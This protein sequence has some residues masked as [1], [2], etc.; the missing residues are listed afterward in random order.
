MT[1]LAAQLVVLG[2]GIEQQRTG[3][4]GQWRQRQQVV[5]LEIGDE[6]P[7]ARR[8]RRLE[9]RTD[10]A[11]RRHD[12]LDQ[13]VRMAQ[14]RAGRLVVL[15]RLA[16]PHQ[17]LVHQ[18]RLDQRQRLH[19]RLLARHVRDA[20]PEVARRPP[21]RPRPPSGRTP[22]AAFAAPFVASLGLPRRA[23]SPSSAASISPQHRSQHRRRPY[24]AL[25]G[26]GCSEAAKE[27]GASVGRL[28][29]AR[30]SPAGSVC[31]PCSA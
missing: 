18:H 6:Q 4:I 10:V 28:A 23:L 1:G 20:R 30:C 2:A 12:P 5:L 31:W 17:P 9:H 7:L 19:R 26:Y 15:E 14:E 11:V 25:L 3:G 21:R 8:Q 22:Q 29:L 13:L 27:R 24:L 16:R